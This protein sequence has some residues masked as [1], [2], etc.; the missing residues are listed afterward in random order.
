LATKIEAFNGRGHE[1]FLGSRDFGDMIS[2]IDGREELV[3]EVQRS[4]R[5]C[6]PS[7]PANSAACERT[8][9]SAKGSLGLSGQTLRAG[10]LFN[11]P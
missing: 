6:A 8:R 10:L 11:R 3:A 5:I 4:E 1:D 9:A 7:S 2:L